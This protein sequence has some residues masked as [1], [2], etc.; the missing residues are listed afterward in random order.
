[1]ESKRYNRYK[2]AG[3]IAFAL[4][5]NLVYVSRFNVNN[6]MGDLS[7]DLNF[8][9]DQQS[10]ISMSV[11]LSYAA[12][13]FVNGYLVDRYGAKKM[14]LLGAGFSALLNLTVIFQNHWIAILCL[15]LANG[16]F[17]SMIWIGGIAFVAGNVSCNHISSA[18]GAGNPLAWTGLEDE[19]GNSNCRI[20][21]DGGPVCADR[22]GT[23]GR[24]WGRTLFD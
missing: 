8:T 5:Y 17:Q 9:E 18:A 7:G 4:M 12:G 22:G 14:I 23:S 15:W 11:F 19:S 10:L 20:S 3:L 13:S 16:Y 1:M 2:W 6:L 21:A 24:D